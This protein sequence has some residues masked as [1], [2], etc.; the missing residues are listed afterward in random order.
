MVDLK[1]FEQEI[2]TYIKPTTLPLAIKL[3]LGR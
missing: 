1:S 3:E 2:Q